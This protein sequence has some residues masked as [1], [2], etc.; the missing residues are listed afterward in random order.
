MFGPGSA[1]GVD[2]AEEQADAVFKAAAVFVGALV[3]EGREEFVEQVAVGGVNLDEV[4]AGAEGALGGLD[5]GGDEHLDSRGVEGLGDGVSGR[6]GDGGGSDGGPCTLFGGEEAF[7]VEGR[8]HAAFAA[9]VGELDAGA[10]ALGVEEGGDALEV[11]DV[12]VFPDAEVGGGD[13]AFGGDGGGFKGDEASS[14]LGASAEVDEMPVS[15]KA[16]FAVVLAHGGYADAVGER[17]GTKLEGREKWVT[18]ACGI[19]SPWPW[20]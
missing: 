20:I 17:D 11:G 12:F 13:A 6:E 14:A 1:D 10:G 4:E 9:G 2:D 16:V 18:H 5:E 8:G 19:A 15:G 7:A 3:G